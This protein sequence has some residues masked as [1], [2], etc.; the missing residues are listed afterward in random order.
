MSADLG[1]DLIKVRSS[2]RLVKK[3]KWSQQFNTHGLFLVAWL[4]SYSPSEPASLHLLVIFMFWPRC[5]GYCRCF[6]KMITSHVFKS[7]IHPTFVM[8][9]SASCVY[10]LRYKMALPDVSYPSKL[11]QH[12]RT[13][14]ADPDLQEHRSGWSDW[15]WE[16]MKRW[17]LW[18]WYVWAE[19]GFTFCL[20]KFCH[21]DLISSIPVRSQARC[22]E[23]NP[24]KVHKSAHRRHLL[25]VLWGSFPQAET[26]SWCRACWNC[27]RMIA[28][29]L[30]V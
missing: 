26:C 10:H 18:F 15:V 20:L 30:V 1:M 27:L 2:L 19:D 23:T 13:A 29:G 8:K 17:L 22:R 21:Q 16:D 28:L 3:S 14:P 7:D 6:G 25:A 5:R 4:G 9:F 24:L 12:R 11:S